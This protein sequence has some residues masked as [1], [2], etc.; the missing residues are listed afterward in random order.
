MGRHRKKKKRAPRYDS[1]EQARRM[2][3]AL[4]GS[5]PAGRVV[6]SRKQKPAKHKKRDI[7][8]ELES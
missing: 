5:P 7:E 3:R 4:L 6:P 8:R 2:A 1:A